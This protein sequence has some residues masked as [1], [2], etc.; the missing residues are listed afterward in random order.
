VDSWE[1][2][3]KDGTGSVVYLSLQDDLCTSSVISNKGRDGAVDADADR[4]RTS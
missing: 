4:P 3:S 1:A 2:G